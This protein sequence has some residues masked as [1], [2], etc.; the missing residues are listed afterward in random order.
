MRQESEARPVCVLGAV[1]PQF[2]GSPRE[3]TNGIRG[4]A[5]VNSVR[6]TGGNDAVVILW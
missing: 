3:C 4:P 1:G 6:C 5:T 2:A